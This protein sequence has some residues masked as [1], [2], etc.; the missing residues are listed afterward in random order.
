MPTN[1]LG[2]PDSFGGYTAAQAA[3]D[4]AY[5][6]TPAG[7]MMARFS[8]YGGGQGF[9]AAIGNRNPNPFSRGVNAKT[10]F[11]SRKQAKRIF[12]PAFGAL[13]AQNA[14]L[15]PTLDLA[16]R[17]A[18][19]YGDIWRTEAGKASAGYDEQNPELA[20]LLHLL[21]AD[22]SSLV[23]GGNNPLEDRD[24]VQS[25][26]AAQTARGL[27]LGGGDALAE[28]LGLDRAREGRRM[29]RGS[30][31]AGI[32]NTGENY[33][34][35]ALQ[36][37]LKGGPVGGMQAPQVGTSGDDLLSVGINDTMSRRN[38]H[39]ARV[40]GNQALIG[41]GIEA[42]GSILGGALGGKK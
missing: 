26:R 41:S 6:A 30:Y 18:A 5:R 7:Q 37:L 14:L 22:A 29:A 11:E 17:T 20:A 15:A 35:N 21:T 1:L 8:A 27:G 40:A 4:A 36:T 39:Q 24:T 42:V 10:A 13:A 23:A 12:A 31:G 38:M 25:I 19:G 34:M 33:Y 2:T 28:L 3:A 9:G 32:L 16:G